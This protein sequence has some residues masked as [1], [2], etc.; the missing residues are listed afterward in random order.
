MSSWSPPG[1]P[2]LAA[3]SAVVAAAVCS[4][5]SCGLLWGWTWVRRLPA[6]QPASP[7][8]PSRSRSR[9]SPW[10][11][12]ALAA[13]P[14][15]LQSAAALKA[16][17]GV[18]YV[19]A[20]RA[21]PLLVV[22][23]LTSLSA[24]VSLQQLSCSSRVVSAVLLADCARGSHFP[25]VAWGVL[26]VASLSGLLPSLGTAAF[27]A[28]S[29]VSAA[30][31]VGAS[32][33]ASSGS[34]AAADGAG[35]S[36]AVTVAQALLLVVVV[37]GCG[38]AGARSRREQEAVFDALVRKGAA[39]SAAAAAGACDD[40]VE[41]RPV[42]DD[43]VDADPPH[44]RSRSEAATPPRSTTPSPSL[45][46]SP[47]TSTTTTESIE[48]GSPLLPEQAG[49]LLGRGPEAVVVVVVRA[50]G[51]D[52]A[53]LPLPQRLPHLPVGAEPAFT[54]PE[55]RIRVHA[56]GNPAEEAAGAP[57][58]A[59]A[60]PAA[61]PPPEGPPGHH[62]LFL[63][64]SAPSSAPSRHPSPA[65]VFPVLAGALDL[66]LQ[67][68]LVLAREV[69]EGAD[70]AL[71]MGRG[72]GR[73]R[74]RGRTT[75]T[76]ATSGA[77]VAGAAGT[78]GPAVRPP[79][80]A[81][82]ADH[83]RRRVPSPQRLGY[84]TTTRRVLRAVSTESAGGGG[85]GGGG[86]G[87]LDFGD[88]EAGGG[89][90]ADEEG[91]ADDN[92]DE[93][94]DSSSPAAKAA[95]SRAAVVKLRADSALLVSALRRLG[96]SVLRM[97]LLSGA[98]EPSLRPRDVLLELTRWVSAEGRSL[99]LGRRTLSIAW[100]TGVPAEVPVDFDL[101]EKVLAYLV[102]FAAARTAHGE[103]IVVAVGMVGDGT[104]SDGSLA[105]T[106]STTPSSSPSTP[107]SP[108]TSAST[109]LLAPAQLPPHGLV[110]PASASS[111]WLRVEVI[112]LPTVPA[113][114]SPFPATPGQWAAAAALAASAGMPATPAAAAAA[115]AAT[116]A[117]TTTRAGGGAG[118]AFVG[119]QTPLGAGGA[120]FPFSSSAS[121]SSSSTAF[122]SSS[123]SE[124]ASAV[125]VCE[126]LARLL[127]GRIGVHG[128][129]G[130]TLRRA[131][132]ES[133]GVDDA[134]KKGAWLATGTCAWFLDLPAAGPRVASAAEP[135]AA[136]V[137]ATAPSS[138]YVPIVP[139]VPGRTADARRAA[140]DGVEATSPL[141]VSRAPPSGA[142]P[143][144]EGMLPGASGS[145][146]VSGPRPSPSL[147]PS[148]AAEPATAPFMS[149]T[150]TAAAAA[151]AAAA[152]A[153]TTWFARQDAVS[154]ETGTGTAPPTPA[155]D[156]ILDSDA[157]FLSGLPPSSSS[158]SHAILPRAALLPRSFLLDGDEG[159]REEGRDA[160]DDRRTSAEGPAS[161]GG[162]SAGGSSAGGGSSSSGG[163]AS[164][165]GGGGGGGYEA[166]PPSTRRTSATTT[167]SSGGTRSQTST[168]PR[169]P[170]DMSTPVLGQSG[171]NTGCS[172]GSAGA[173]RGG[174][175]SAGGS[176]G[177]REDEYD[178]ASSRTG[179]AGFSRMGGTTTTGTGTP[180]DGRSS[181]SLHKGGGGRGSTTTTT[182]G[183]TSRPGLP[184]TSP[185]SSAAGGG[186]AAR[187]GATSASTVVRD[188]SVLAVSTGLDAGCRGGGTGGRGGDPSAPAAAAFS[189]GATAA[190]DPSSSPPDGVAMATVM[191]LLTSPGG[192]W[193]VLAPPQQQHQG[194]ACSDTSR[195]ALRRWGPGAGPSAFPSSG[196]MG[197]WDVRAFL[198]VPVT[199]A[200]GGSVADVVDQGSPAAQSAR[201]AP[202][203]PTTA[204]GGTDDERELLQ[205]Q[206]QVQ[207]D[208]GSTWTTTTTPRPPS[209]LG[210]L[211]QPPPPALPLVQA[212]QDS[213][214]VHGG[215]GARSL[216]SFGH[217]PSP[218]SFQP[219]T[220]RAGGGGVWGPSSSSS[221]PFAV[222][223]R[224][225]SAGLASVHLQEGD[226]AFYPSS[227]SAA[228]VSFVP[229]IPAPPLAIRGVAA[230]AAALALVDDGTRAPSRG[231][232]SPDVHHHSPH[233][234]VNRR[235]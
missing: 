217:C 169:T 206:Q 64:V 58:G 79:A 155:H 225:P 231:G 40:D 185:S 235:R 203:S 220:P 122:S 42:L 196:T 173:G 78:R 75:P 232:S 98:V 216:P 94:A 60:R 210:L 93:E 66:E 41:R 34:S 13:T 148:A 100:Q 145:A 215:G 33:A 32:V 167:Q 108:T 87:P 83:D 50:E 139:R 2:G 69:A 65:P 26:L 180:L 200:A 138:P 144:S 11:L 178:D 127:G 28:Q 85:G 157:F 16:A 233:H 205:Q 218:L 90:G 62:A 190:A 81:A 91:D 149:S 29:V 103:Q 137:A 118:S 194:G 166:S 197:P 208:R 121:A 113:A 47:S 25:A 63:P 160:N 114:A 7:S 43:G 191:P 92:E 8:P 168:A 181:T 55:G 219:P 174:A 116:T 202:F 76:H 221:A 165:G 6:P 184:V 227:S 153:S 147:P 207:R 1:A 133:H 110:V 88:F 61:P 36:A 74:A 172:G 95:A 52:G 229:G 104:L 96:T 188:P 27:A 214:E 161:E 117:A 120:P 12:T 193:T 102:G 222:R 195:E 163:G 209:G 4:L 199:V 135:A 48:L 72:K 171:R 51:E 183:G 111:G 228:L 156:P 89:Y 192:A 20:V 126:G 224:P 37:L 18:G 187:S 86:E 123:A 105:T 204:G 54:A 234:P 150:M 73:G 115:A 176:G 70:G 59:A 23:S 10:S 162:S 223:A 151:A 154:I 5:A 112:C 158:S 82:A 67:F 84:G 177:G 124:G 132:W 99:L 142:R 159:G 44:S 125:G 31:L 71:T 68:A 182:R 201:A 170:S 15:G 212:P 77:D 21:Q 198:R 53:V 128:W 186:R 80:A 164:G 19:L 140:P 107:S 141:F 56:H 213:S 24:A 211:L 35:A 17:G 134:M 146:S 130:H 131:I 175:G 109:P 230:A 129:H 226:P 38:I 30:V 136:P 49:P 3:G 9:S 101:V 189:V 143:P 57:V 39:A 179:S 14:E 22:A 46:S 97:R 106:P 152:P 45:S 119:Q